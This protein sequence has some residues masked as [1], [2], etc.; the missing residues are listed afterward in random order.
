MVAE[1]KEGA[2]PTQCFSSTSFVIGAIITF[3]CGHD[4][5]SSCQEFLKFPFSHFS[6]SVKVTLYL[7]SVPE[8][9]AV[10]FADIILEPR[11]IV[12]YYSPLIKAAISL[13]I[14]PLL[15][16]PLKSFLP[17]SI[18][19]FNPLHTLSYPLVNFLHD[20]SS[21]LNT[22]SLCPS[23][24]SN[25]IPLF[26]NILTLSISIF[27]YFL[28]LFIFFTLTVSSLSVFAPLV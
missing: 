22:L 3:Y 12:I 18:S 1:F 25:F 4:T 16:L 6:S 21:K 9:R 11:N 17:S 20:P 2:G 26:L 24:L 19:P 27:L 10:I 5:F 14:P 15:S 13:S 8:M 28:L 23:L 7:H